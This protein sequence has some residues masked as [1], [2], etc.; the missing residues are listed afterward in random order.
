[1]EG[2]S[3][4]LPRYLVAA[5]LVRLADEG[6][7]VALVLLALDRTGSAGLGGLLVAALLVPH[8]LAAPAVG[9]VTDRARRP[10]RVIAT[11][12]AGYALALATAALTV[13]RTPPA[14]PFM[15]L[16]AGGACGP[17]LLGGLSSQLSALVPEA[18]LPRAFGL[19]SLSYN[20]SG[21]VGP[22]L[23]GLLGGLASPAVA[24]LTLAASAASGAVVLATV[25][26]DRHP[27]GQ[28]SRLRDG[29]LVMLRDRVLGVVTAASSVGQ[30]GAG[31]LPVA[32]AVLAGRHAAPAA[33]GALMTAVAAGGLAGSLAWTW[34]PLPAARAPLAVMATS[35]G[36]GAPLA[37]VPGSPSLGVTAALFA[38][39]GFFIGPFTGA[40][41][42]TRQEHAPSRLRAQVFSL[43]GGLKTTSA[44]AGAALAGAV[45]DLS[46]ATQF[47]LVAACPLTAGLA[48]ALLLIPGP[49]AAFGRRPPLRR[50]EPDRVPR[51]RRARPPV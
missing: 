21:I 5:V 32:A 50:E 35:V 37:L 17:A 33:T 51:L 43:G 13:G 15:V 29:A 3:R 25:P 39:S 34:K 26:L 27:A 46:T 30:L 40:L 36:M 47:L 28:P 10:R 6:A 7:R 24:T 23:A 11:A 1:M 4:G 12:A 31:A 18:S 8:V 9:L 19:D 49:R 22:A 41:F 48:G 38:L 2:R 45:A 16:V 14:V 44:A 42:T 20:V